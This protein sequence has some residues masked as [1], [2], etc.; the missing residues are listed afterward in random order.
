MI[1]LSNSPFHYITLRQWANR[2]LFHH[3]KFNT[4]NNEFDYHNTYNEIEKKF[5]ALGVQRVEEEF[6]GIVD[7]SII[8]SLW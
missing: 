5:D 6:V 8:R 4:N 1:K 2:D 3:M 7:D